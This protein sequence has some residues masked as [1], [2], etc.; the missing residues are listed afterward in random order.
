MPSES[1]QFA[2]A[3]ANFTHLVIPRA[4]DITGGAHGP[5]HPGSITSIVAPFLYLV[6]LNCLSFMLL[7]VVAKLLLRAFEL[8]VDLLNFFTASLYKLLPARLRTIAYHAKIPFFSSRKKGKRSFAR[9]RPHINADTT[10]DDWEKVSSKKDRA[11][12]EVEGYTEVIQAL[13]TLGLKA[14]ANQK[15]IRSAYIALMKQYH[16]DLYTTASPEEQKKIRAAAL[17]IRH[18]YDTVV[19]QFDHVH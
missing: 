12:P 15:E 3:L 4:L 18:A 6:I 16:P 10:S 7:K 14:S 17:E 11:Q 1:N 19:K 13:R 8:A 2:D 5:G 9:K